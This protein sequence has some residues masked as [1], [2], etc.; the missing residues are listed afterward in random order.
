MTGTGDRVADPRTPDTWQQMLFDQLARIEQRFNELMT[1]AEWAAHKESIDAS[2][3]DMHRR[4]DDVQTRS[5]TALA[6]LKAESWS[7]HRELDAD[8]E[9]VKAAATEDRKSRE[10]EGSQRRFTVVMAVFSGV[11]A[12]ANGVV[13]LVVTGVLGG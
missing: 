2:M 8:I 10:K 5:A 7:V 9:S 1:R 4:I 3:R 6:D 13:L 12:L 11:L